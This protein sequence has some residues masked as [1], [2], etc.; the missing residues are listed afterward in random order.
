ME[1]LTIAVR[2][3]CVS[4]EVGSI[5]TSAV[6]VEDLDKAIELAARLGVKTDP[7]SVALAGARIARKIRQAVL[8]EDWGAVDEVGYLINRLF[9]GVL[10]VIWGRSRGLFIKGLFKYA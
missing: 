1:A 4:G 5:D 2:E 9:R 7:A 10:D 3:G 8:D 6:R